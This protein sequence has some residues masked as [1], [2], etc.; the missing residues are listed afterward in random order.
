MVSLPTRGT[1]SPLDGFLG[2]QPHGPAGAAFRRVAADHGD[3]ALLLAVV[4]HR[5]RSGPLLLIQRG[6]QTALLV[7]MADLANGLWRQRTTPAIR[8]ALTPLANCRSA[9]ARRT[10]RTC[11][12]PPL[13]SFVEFLLI[14]G[15]TS[16]RRAGRPISVC[17]KTFLLK[18]GFYQFF[19]RSKT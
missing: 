6:F 10:T 9:K 13:N 2:H 7:A 14:L 18:I 15:A 16:I 8:G 12:T 11:C 5:G 19:R 3:D 17:A 1:S 4:Q